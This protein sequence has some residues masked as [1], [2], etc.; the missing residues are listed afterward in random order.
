ME[1]KKIDIDDSRNIGYIKETDETIAVVGLGYVGLPLGIELSKKYATVLG[2]DISKARVAELQDNRDQTNEVSTEAITDSTI[3][4]THDES[5]LADAT[6][7]LVTVPTPIDASKRPDLS[8]LRGACQLIG[9]YLN[10][11]DLVVF[12][13]TVYP[14]VTEDICA[15]ILAEVSGLK[16]SS[17][18]WIGYSAERI[19]PGD[20]VRPLT[21]IVKNVAG[22]TLE[23]RARV[24]KIYAS[25]I[26]AGVFET[27]SIR[28]AEAAKVLENT[29][30]DVNIALMNELALICHLMDVRTVDVIEAA[31]TKWNF[32]PYTP[33]LVGGHCISVDPYYLTA[34]AE[35]LGYHPEVI[36][37]G[38]RIND[39]MSRYVA[40]S[41]IKLLAQK[42]SSIRSA[43]VGIWGITFKENVPDLRNSKVIELIDELRSFGLTPVAHDPVANAAEAASLGVELVSYADM[44]DLDLAIL[45]VPHAEYLEEIELWRRLG[46][47]G[48]MMDVKSVL[49]NVEKP[50]GVTYW[51]L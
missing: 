20:K 51:C 31:A 26:D 11:G 15:P 37:A 4:L 9:K 3:R 39:N 44:V 49:R 50:D 34:R 46:D 8:P 36:L 13:S 45:A 38:R 30:R 27:A 40:Q 23:T 12:E 33:G 43:R 22:D 18:F 48:I 32:T 21:K 24:A 35:E 42:P 19:S 10:K 28:V 16:A 7:Y 5:A 47:E 6:V 17:D 1:L 2:F 25:I 29:Q 14:G 41:A